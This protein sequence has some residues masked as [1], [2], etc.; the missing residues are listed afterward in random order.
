MI[1]ALLLGSPFKLGQN[2]PDGPEISRTTPSKWSILLYFSQQAQ[3]LVRLPVK[4]FEPL[5]VAK[6]IES[7][8]FVV[9]MALQSM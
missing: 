1:E 2:Q 5:E 6:T 9:R 3:R 4:N 8:C 7:A